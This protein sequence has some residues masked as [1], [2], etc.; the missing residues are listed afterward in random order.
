MHPTR[1]QALEICGLAAFGKWL[2]AADRF[3]NIEDPGQ[4]T[5]DEIDR[6]LTRSPWAREVMVG[7]IPGGSN[8]HRPWSESVPGLSLPGGP[9]PRG[10]QRDPKAVRSGQQA[11]VCWA[12]AAPVL[13]ATKSPLPETFRER[14][15]IA[16]IGLPV[17]SE[18][19]DKL[20]DL[21]QFAS[22]RPKG[23]DLVQPGVVEWQASSRTL[24]FGFSRE[25]LPLGKADREVTFAAKVARFEVKASF[26]LNEMYYRGALAL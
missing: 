12:S 14:Y 2:I 1:R 10:K 19:R 21:K 7:V 18:Q 25:I 23:R 20:D 16:V 17:P 26:L 3:W 9:A 15:T 5:P 6:L 8:D 13:A 4:W 22:L 11:T 24:L